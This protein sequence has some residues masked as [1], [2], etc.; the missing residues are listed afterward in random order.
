MASVLT[1][2]AFNEPYGLDQTAKRWEVFGKMTFV[3]GNYITGGLLPNWGEQV[4]NVL[5]PLQ[6][7][8][9]ENLLL[10]RYTQPSSFKITNSA[11]TSN[12][13]TI[14]AANS[15][16]ALQWVTFQGMTNLPFLNG[17]TLQVIATGLS[18]TQF[19]V[20]FTHANVAS[21]AEAGSAVLVIGPD[22]MI[23]LQ[24]LSGSG[25]EYRYNKA[26]ASIQIFTTGTASGDAENELAAGALPAA[27]IADIVHFVASYVKG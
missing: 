9:G 1:M 3:A 18:A 23:Q 11:L 8:D 19:E 25:Y 20:N 12:V 21:A 27:V 16:T 13:V 14:T 4:A 17:L 6:Y 24:S 7:T 5:G 22:T 15:L 26:N 2:T 10:A